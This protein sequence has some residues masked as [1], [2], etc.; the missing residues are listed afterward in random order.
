[1]P[2][3]PAYLTA[4]Q[5]LEDE[6]RQRQMRMWAK[7]QEGFG[8]AAVATGA[9]PEAKYNVGREEA[10]AENAFFGRKPGSQGTMVTPTGGIVD[11]GAAPPG[12]RARELIGVLSQGGAQIPEYVDPKTGTLKGR[13]AGGGNYW[14]KLI[15][16][17]YSGTPNLPAW[18]LPE[19]HSMIGNAG[20]DAAGEI[21]AART[22]AGPSPLD[23]YISPAYKAEH[24]EW[25]AIQEGRNQ[26]YQG[27]VGKELAGITGFDQPYDPNTIGK[28][29]E[30]IE[31]QGAGLTDEQMRRRAEWLQ[32]RKRF[33]EAHNANV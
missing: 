19:A 17:A 8:N 11:V 26:E 21:A 33:L 25:G 1:M 2:R 14:D 22:A 7:I 29:S 13:P 3:Q 31:I 30:Q 24:P 10:S 16:A 20:G 28:G 9:S 15:G 32:A 6:Q 27:R 18:H 23:D 4:Q 12:E 5:E